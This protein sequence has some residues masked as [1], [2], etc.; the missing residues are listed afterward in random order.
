MSEHDAEKALGKAKAKRA[1]VR[2]A[3][4][5][6]RYFMCDEGYYHLTSQSR[7]TFQTY[8]LALTS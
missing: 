6:S 3:Q 2:G 5:E 8:E 4:M 7:R 1:R